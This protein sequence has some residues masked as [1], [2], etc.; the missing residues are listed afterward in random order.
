[1]SK[2]KW[3]YIGGAIL[4]LLIV[5]VSINKER[6]F[7]SDEEK[8][9]EIITA[10]QNEDID[11]LKEYMDKKYPLTFLSKEGYTPLEMALNQRAFPIVTLLLKNDAGVNEKAAPLYVQIVSK[12]DD[13]QQIGESPNYQKTIK[14]YINLLKIASEKQAAGINDRDEYGHTA[15][16]YAA[17]LGHPDIIK[18]LIQLGAEPVAVN[19]DKETPLMLAVKAGQT[20]AVQILYAYYDQKLDRDIEGNSLLISAAMNGRKEALTYLLKE[21][22]AEIN[23]QNLVGKTALIIA[24]EYGYKEIV[25]VLLQNGADPLIKSKEEK[26]ALEYAR[27]WEHQDIVS[28]LSEE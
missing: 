14:T 2:N 19:K 11:K 20:Q 17:R 1:M 10:I 3:I 23:A 13:Y 24:A 21:S 5:L 8:Q 6:F 7:K 27:Q 18:Y 16:H 25:A 28:L 4:I 15:L 9:S 26:M 22:K 12:L